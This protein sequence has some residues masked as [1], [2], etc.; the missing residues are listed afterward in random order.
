MALALE[1]AAALNAVYAAWRSDVVV[2][3]PVTDSA[4][5][6]LTSSVISEVIHDSRESLLVVSFAAFGV[7]DVVRELE[8]AARRGVHST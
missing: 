1:S 5:V 2:S 3:G 4:P 6:R 7:A 8:A